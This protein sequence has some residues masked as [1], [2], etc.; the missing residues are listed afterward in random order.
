MTET[1]RTAV[2]VGGRTTVAPVTAATTTAGTLLCLST[3][4]GSVP[5]LAGNARGSAAVAEPRTCG[6]RTRLTFHPPIQF[7]NALPAVT[8]HILTVQ[9]TAVTLGGASTIFRSVRLYVQ[10]VGGG[11]PIVTATA[12]SI[13]RGAITV[14]SSSTAVLASTLTYGIG[15]RMQLTR[16]AVVSAAS[17]V[18][19]AEF[20]VADAGRSNAVVQERFALTFT[21]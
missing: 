4:T 9:L 8:G 16:A 7:A 11:Y 19:V 3:A 13:V 17:I 14:A 20:V 12:V 18:I 5:F 1:F 6:S 2:P 15:F 10:T 21:Y